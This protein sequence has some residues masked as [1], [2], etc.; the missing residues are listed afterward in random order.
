[1]TRSTG[2]LIAAAGGLIA[3]LATP[4]AVLAHA[5]GGTFQLPVP[6]WLYL[7]GAAIA[8]GASFVVTSFVVRDEDRGAKAAY[9]ARPVPRSLA[10]VARTILRV[11][12]LAWWYGAIAVGL[13]IGDISPLPGVLLWVG[14][15]V[16]LPIAAVLIGNAWPSLSPFRTTFAALDWLGRRAGARRVDAGLRYPPGLARWPAVALLAIG[17]WAELVLPGSSSAG[18]VAWASAPARCS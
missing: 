10:S 4:G 2:R 13:F 3:L 6:L 18:T 8:V 12:G 5:I 11:L 16:G 9:A 7:A 1:M 17:I 15:W 14:I